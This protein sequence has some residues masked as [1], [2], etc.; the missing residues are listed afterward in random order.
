MTD[1]L[2]SRI[3]RC[4]TL[5]TKPSDFAT[6]NCSPDLGVW[7]IEIC[8][9]SLYLALCLIALQECKQASKLRRGVE[10][11]AETIFQPQ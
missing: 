4:L 10:N 3:L 9:D 11:V 7:I 2:S 1:C 8:K 6:Y 5:V